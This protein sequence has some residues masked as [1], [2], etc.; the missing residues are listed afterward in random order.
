MFLPPSGPT[1]PKLRSAMATRPRLRRAA[2]AAA[3]GTGHGRP[4]RAPGR[5]GRAAT[6]P[7]KRDCVGAFQTTTRHRR[8]GR[9]C[10]ERHDVK[11]GDDEGLEQAP[12]EPQC[13]RVG[14]SMLVSLACQCAG[15]Q[16]G[17]V[18][19][20]ENKRAMCVLLPYPRRMRDLQP[21]HFPPQSGHP[22]F[23]PPRTRAASKDGEK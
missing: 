21:I 14:V 18:H 19:L 3:A 7:P 17:D 12:P 16:T 9:A 4:G 1:P 15:T 13:L 23:A 22:T 10:R 11:T 2:A 6:P 5:R 20:L 8:R